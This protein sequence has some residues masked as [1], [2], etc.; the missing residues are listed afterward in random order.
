MIAI[1]G[2]SAIRSR[3]NVIIGPKETLPVST[4]TS[5]GQA[6]IYKPP[7]VEAPQNV[8]KAITQQIAASPSIKQNTITG[9][10]IGANRNKLP[11]T[12]VKN[13][14]ST[15][16]VLGLLGVALFAAFAWDRGKL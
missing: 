14:G 11:V 13:H 7:T 6:A 5:G 4:G 15:Y 16:I 3:I 2:L 8:T 12:V 10:G 1:P 9:A